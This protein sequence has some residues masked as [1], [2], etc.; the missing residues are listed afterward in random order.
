MNKS[1]A[2]KLV[3]QMRDYIP[4]GKPVDVRSL[5][6]RRTRDHEVLLCGTRTGND[7]QS[8]PYY[9]GAVADWV[10]SIREGTVAVCDRHGKQLNI[11]REG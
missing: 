6:F 5:T 3:E 11:K 10:A 1:D 7:I 9:C 8:G 4:G 2:K